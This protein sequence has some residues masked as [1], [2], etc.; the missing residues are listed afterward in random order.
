MDIVIAN[1]SKNPTFDGDQ[2]YVLPVSALDVVNSISAVLS[3]IANAIIAFLVLKWTTLRT[4]SNIYLA[5]WCLCNF[6]VLVSAPVTVNLFGWVDE[7]SFEVLCIWEETLNGILFG[8]LVFVTIFL[9]DWY[10]VTLGTQNCANRCGNCAKVINI[11]VWV[12]IMVLSTASVVLCVYNYSYPLT[13]MSYFIGYLTMF[14]IMLTIFI[15]R[16]VKVYLFH[17]LEKSKVELV[18]VVSYFICWL[19]NCACLYV[20]LL[21]QR[22]TYGIMD[23]TYC[24]GYINACVLLVILYCYDS[25]FKKCFRR[26]FGL[27]SELSSEDNNVKNARNSVL[28]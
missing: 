20:E 26:T 10:S 24:V 7:I 13:L 14:L 12:V 8:N 19:P 15:L 22:S 11:I 18:L 25:N 21:L 6:F 16:C 23:G 9:I 27:E 3:C 1:L 5:S 4:R 2:V 28:L 17:S